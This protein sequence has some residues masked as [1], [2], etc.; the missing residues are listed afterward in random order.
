MRHIS[1]DD[2]FDKVKAEVE[3]LTSMSGGKVDWNAISNRDGAGG[4]QLA[5]PAHR[6]GDALLQRRLGRL[7]D[8]LRSEAWSASAGKGSS[9]G[10][11]T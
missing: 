10:R 11:R 3:K 7:A 5:E 4:D 8:D 6:V 2:A 9:H 1:F